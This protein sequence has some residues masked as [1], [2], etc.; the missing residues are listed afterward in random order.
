MA[1]RKPFKIG[2]K[3]YK[4]KKDAIAYY[5][6]ILNSYDFGESLNDANYDD[7]IDL[8]NYN[9]FNYLIDI[10]SSEQEIE[11]EVINDKDEE[12]DENDIVIEDIKVSKVQFNNKCFEVFYS[13]NTSEYISYLM[14]INNK[15]YKPEDL[16]YIACR[17]SIHQDIHS[18]K[19][20]YFSKQVN[21]KVKCQETGILSTWEELVID[22]RQPNTLSIIV[23]RFK[24]VN[25]INL[26]SI[27]YITDK[28]NKF[29]FKEEELNLKFKLYHKEKA[30]LRIVRIECNASRTGMGRV[31]RSSKDLVI[32]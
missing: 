5:R 24:E 10:E 9:Y 7:I 8:L 1:K 13:N 14:I 28:D 25:K 3:E 18:V 19:S 21:R 2:K 20:N 16:F 22:H 30:T 27:E 11:E 12:I 23:D 32:E 29:I 26:D 4:F 15:K 17:N 6:L 31:K